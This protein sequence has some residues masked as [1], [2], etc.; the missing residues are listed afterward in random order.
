[1]QKRQVTKMHSLTVV[2]N[3][4]F[5]NVGG[6]LLFS[7]ARPLERMVNTDACISGMND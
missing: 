7:P 5:V 1:M 2:Q 6:D 4:G 3:S